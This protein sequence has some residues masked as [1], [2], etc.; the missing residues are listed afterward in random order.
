[1]IKEFESFRIDDE[2]TFYY[3]KDKSG[4]ES[5]WSY[6]LDELEY[7]IKSNEEEIKRLTKRLEEAQ[8]GYLA[9]EEKNKRLNNKVEELMTLYTTEREV[10]DY[11]KNIIKELEKWLE[12]INKLYKDTRISYVEA[13]SDAL[14]KLQKL[15]GDDKE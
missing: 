7:Y 3:Y 11:Y 13:I 10:K 14:D 5:Q 9:V 6:N 1:M 4:V 2:G 15:K 12:N 8:L